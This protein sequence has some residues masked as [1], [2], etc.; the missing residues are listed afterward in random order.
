MPSYKYLFFKFKF[1]PAF[2]DVSKN[3][4][5]FL[6]DILFKKTYFIHAKSLFTLCIKERMV[7]TSQDIRNLKEVSRVGRKKYQLCTF[8]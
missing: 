8:L 3:N 2:L 6:P 4:V 1:N 5:Y 7:D